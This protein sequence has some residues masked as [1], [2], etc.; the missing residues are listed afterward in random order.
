[1]KNCLEDIEVVEFIKNNIKKIIDVAGKTNIVFPSYKA[2]KEELKEN[3]RAFAEAMARKNLAG[4]DQL[5]RKNKMIVM[6]YELAVALREIEENFLQEI[7][8]T[9]KRKGFLIAASIL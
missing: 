3:Y 9:C 1:M 8:T 4:Y 2:T 5:T 6:I 7:K